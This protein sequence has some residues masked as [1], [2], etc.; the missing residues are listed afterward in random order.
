M[1]LDLSHPQAYIQTTTKDL[2]EWA[3]LGVGGED[4]DD[5]LQNR[6]VVYIY[7]WSQLQW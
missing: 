6:C 1:D 2:E 5:D 7:Q 4:D 3:G